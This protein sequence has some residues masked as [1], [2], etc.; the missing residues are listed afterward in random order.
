MGEIGT[1]GQLAAVCAFSYVYIAAKAFQQLNVM[2]GYEHLVPA[3]T[4]IMAVCEVGV[5]GAIAYETMKGTFSGLAGLVVVM[6]I[7]SSL[8]AITSMRLHKRLRNRRKA[9]GKD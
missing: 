1:L 7:G 9:S 2:H 8:G 6:T 5:V 3:V 4:F